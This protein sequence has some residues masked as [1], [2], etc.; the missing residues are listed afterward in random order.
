MDGLSVKKLGFSFKVIFCLFTIKF[1]S[2][3]NS[4]KVELERLHKLRFDP[5]VLLL[6][7]KMSQTARKK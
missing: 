1:R 7:I 3:L 2:T 4:L 5:S 6:M